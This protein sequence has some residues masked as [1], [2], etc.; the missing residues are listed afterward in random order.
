M[1]Q[2]VLTVYDPDNPGKSSQYTGEFVDD[3]FHGNGKMIYSN[4]E[5]YEGEWQEGMRH[6]MGQMFYQNGVS[7]RGNWQYDKKHSLVLMPDGGYAAGVGT[8]IYPIS[9]ANK[10]RLRQGIWVDDQEPKYQ[11][12]HYVNGSKYIGSVD[13]Y[14]QFQEGVLTLKTPFGVTSYTGI[15]QD[16]HL[17]SGT[18]VYASGA[19]YQ[20]E[21]RGLRRDG[22]GTLTDFTGQAYT[23]EWYKDGLREEV[24]PNNKYYD[25]GTK[26]VNGVVLRHGTGK[27]TYAN[28]SIYSGRWEEDVPLFM[29][30]SKV[31]QPSNTEQAQLTAQAVGLTYNADVGYEALRYDTGTYYGEVCQQK[32]DGVGVMIY[33]NGSK[34]QGKWRNGMRH[35]KG[36]MLYANGT[37]CIGI[38]VDDRG[39]YEQILMRNKQMPEVCSYQGGFVNGSPHGQG[40]LCAYPVEVVG[41]SKDLLVKRYEGTWEHGNLI[42]GTIEYYNGGKYT[43]AISAWCPGGTGTKVEFKHRGVVCKIEGGHGTMVFANG[44]IYTGVWPQSMFVNAF[45]HNPACHPCGFY[46]VTYANGNKFTGVIAPYGNDQG[47]VFTYPAGHKYKTFTITRHSCNDKK[48]ALEGEIVYANGDRYIGRVF[49]NNYQGQ[50]VPVEK[51]K[52]IYVNGDRYDG[53]INQGQPGGKG[54]FTYVNGDS[55]K[56]TFKNGQPDGDGVLT[57]INDDDTVTTITGVWQQGKL[58]STITET[59]T[60]TLTAVASGL[61]K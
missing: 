15:W 54:V 4:G 7:Y 57:K 60:N 56:G 17:F 22:H 61:M 11:I 35:G 5:I 40:S 18:V 58:M 47:G 37:V 34:Y 25:G 49:G 45:Q 9:S 36:K 41:P 3:M 26:I 52:F 59:T 1:T 19:K 38:W 32:P 53:E 14:G 8:I 33:S 55:Y 20:G 48:P 39:I 28:G 23:G 6:G 44:D 43:G 51:G 27:A 12:I 46:D 50:V 2:G 16:N 24:Q 13:N 31:V 42:N 10:I 30:F 29:N 21:V